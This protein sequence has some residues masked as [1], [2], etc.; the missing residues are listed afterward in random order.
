MF[1]KRAGTRSTHAE[2]STSTAYCHQRSGRRE[3]TIAPATADAAI[4]VNTC[5]SPIAVAVRHAANVTSA[6]TRTNAI[7]F[8]HGLTIRSSVDGGETVVMTALNKSSPFHVGT[9]I[10]F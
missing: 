4:H 5:H 9:R 6:A 3:A 7:H 10:Q 8:P 1:C 2:P